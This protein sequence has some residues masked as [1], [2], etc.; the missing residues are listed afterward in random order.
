MLAQR[1]NRPIKP[2]HDGFPS[3]STPSGESRCRF[4]ACSP[5]EAVSNEFLIENAQA[6]DRAVERGTQIP[7]GSAVPGRN[8]AAADDGGKLIPILC[9]GCDAAVRSCRQ[10]LP[11]RSV[12]LT[13][14]A[15]VSCTNKRVI[16]D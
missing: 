2:G 11:S 16:E 4:F 3:D 13:D 6:P 7:P 10:C 15:I 1:A 8:A 5:K 12:P 14:P 9:Q